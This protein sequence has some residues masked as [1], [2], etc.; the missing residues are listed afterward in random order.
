MEQITKPNNLI[1]YINTDCS[2]SHLFNNLSM[3]NK[4]FMYIH[5]SE[6]QPRI[7]SIDKRLLTET[8]SD[9]KISQY[10]DKLNNNE[11]NEMLVL[12]CVLLLD[13]YYIAVGLYGGFKIW[14]LDGNRLLFNIPCKIKVTE[15]PYAFTVISEYKYNS[16]SKQYDSII[17]G[18]NYG[19]IFLVTGSGLNWRGRNI[20]TNDGGLCPTAITSG[21]NTSNYIFVG[22]ETGEASILKLKSDG[23]SSEVVFTIPSP[24][25][26]PCLGMGIIETPTDDNFYLIN[27]YL[28]GEVRIYKKAELS[29]QSKSAPSES[30]ALVSK[31]GAHIRMINC[32]LTYK[33]YFITAGDDCFINI[34]NFNK[35]EKIS[36]HSSYE[37]KDKL[38][39]GIALNIKENGIE[40]ISCT[41]DNTYLALIRIDNLN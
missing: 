23:A 11:I 40:L 13:T 30:F 4:S 34:W 41:Y 12:K 19:Q 2:P 38:P 22:F 1:S 10:V 24:A 31:L 36:L 33:N 3:T 35:D 25:N 5:N 18:D 29:L 6:A 39:V 14:S 9:E 15:K 27:S 16:K 17:C 32:M 8:N 21:L 37:L 28:N 26:L 7:I 20:H